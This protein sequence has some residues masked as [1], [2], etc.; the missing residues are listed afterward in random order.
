[1]GFK[2]FCSVFSKRKSDGL[3]RWVCEKKS[4]KSCLGFNSCEGD[5]FIIVM[6]FTRSSAARGVSCP[7]GQL[8]GVSCPDTLLCT[9]LLPCLGPSI[10]P[11][12]GY[13][14]S[15]P[16]PLTVVLSPLLSKVGCSVLSSRIGH[17]P[18]L[19]SVYSTAL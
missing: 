8:S 18:V 16:P 5:V 13:R 10:P 2:G 19:M 3:E 15:F 6:G 11:S 4:S 9:V 14:I 1:M 7:R 12:G 17:S